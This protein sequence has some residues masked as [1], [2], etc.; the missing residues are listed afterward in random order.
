MKTSLLA[1]LLIFL[2]FLACSKTET[3]TISNNNGIE[4]IENNGIPNKP[5]MNVELKEILSIQGFREDLD[6]KED[7]FYIVKDLEVLPDGSML[8]YDGGSSQV[9]KYSVEGALEMK[10][11]GKGNGPGE[12]RSPNYDIFLFKDKFG[13]SETSTFHLFD[14][15]CNFIERYQVE[16]NSYI[17]CIEVLNSGEFLSIETSADR[18]KDGSFL[19]DKIHKYNSEFERLGT[20]DDEV[21]LNFLDMSTDVEGS[22]INEFTVAVGDNVIYV[23]KRSKEEYTIDCYDFTLNKIKTITCNLVSTNYSSEELSYIEENFVGEYAHP[24][25][26]KDIFDTKLSFN[27]LHYDSSHDYLI[28]EN[29]P[30]LN[31][32]TISFDIF[33]NGIYLNSFEL[34][35]EFDD[36]HPMPEYF[37]LVINNGKLY[38]YSDSLNRVTV[39]EIIYKR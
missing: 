29:S 3:Y 21:R 36:Y 24:D 34:P 15:D 1:L 33:Q 25:Y 18:R 14:F 5:D 6:S 12:V 4:Q 19:L 27:S 13:L 38:H 16:Y 37:N 11:S 8:L 2:A 26:W 32:K 28:V 35:I 22:Y 7:E 17:Y 30:N 31:T 10:F 9:Y 20:I 39:F 23:A